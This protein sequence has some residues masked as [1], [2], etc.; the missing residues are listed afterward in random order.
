MPRDERRLSDYE[1]APPS[2]A[3]ALVLSLVAILVTALALAM[4]GELL[5]ISELES[6]NWAGTVVIDLFAASIACWVDARTVRTWRRLGA[7]AREKPDE[8]ASP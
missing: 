5:V 3:G 8:G 4:I 6:G 2:L 7:P 1:R